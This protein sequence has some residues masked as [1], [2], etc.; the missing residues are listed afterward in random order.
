M[1]VT[2]ENPLESPTE[3]TKEE[4]ADEPS[5]PDKFAILEEDPQ[6]VNVLVVDTS[7]LVLTQQDVAALFPTNNTMV[8][9]ER[10][11]SPSP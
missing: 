4:Q 10:E 5:V 11:L 8:G 3:I 7:A 2:K 1:L 6:E 9:F